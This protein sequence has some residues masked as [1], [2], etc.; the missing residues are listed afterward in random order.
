M[1]M[2]TEKILSSFRTD[3]K[4]LIQIVKTASS[5]QTDPTLEFDQSGVF[6]RMMDNDHISLIDMRIPENFFQSW[7]FKT[8][9]KFSFNAKT[10]LK[11]ISSL[12]KKQS[13]LIEIAEDQLMITQKEFSTSLK[14][15]EASNS[16]CP[17]PRIQFDTLIRCD[18]TDFKNVLKPIE[19]L[20]DY[21]T[22]EKTFDYCYLFGKGDKGSSKIELDTR[23]AF[24]KQN[25]LSE[26]TYSFE[27]L[28][29]F[30][31]S[32]PKNSIIEIEFSTQKPL[33][34]SATLSKTNDV[35]FYLAPRVEN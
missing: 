32:V 17:L 22:I 3:L 25:D 15:N 1:T 12:N 28:K 23:F 29:P 2:E 20:S 31:K 11:I 8:E 30:L 26:S 16:V 10:L 13:V 9:I 18:I 33:R 4:S 6:C 21:V 35:Q 14:I 5:V 34:I 7:T 27:Y 19:T 24:V